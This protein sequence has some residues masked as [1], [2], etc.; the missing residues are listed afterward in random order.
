MA[1]LPRIVR[2]G[3][4]HHVLQRGHNRQPL[5]VD[6]E[7][8]RQWCAFLSDAALRH[9]VALHAWALL[10][11]QFQ[12]VATPA[13]DEALGLMMQ[14]LGRRYAGGF[15]RRHGRSGSLWEGRY[16]ACV[17]EPRQP[18]LDSLLF[19]D[20]LPAR[21]GGIGEAVAWPW[22][23]LRHHLGLQRDPMVTEAPLWWSLG[24]T[25]FEREAR[26][27]QLNEAGLDAAA[28]ASI[29][30]ALRRGWPIGSPAFLDSLQA[31]GG[32]RLAPRPRGRPPKSSAQMPQS[33][34]ERA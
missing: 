17:L 2:A 34:P 5:V 31:P 16:R 12:L 10:D 22:S 11:D 3:Q 27:R 18:L 7:D 8:R 14:S 29:S 13:S 15:N 23:S 26:Y 19:V 4:P 28:L 33:P 6:D 1:R 30:A 20:G 21:E 32:P 9:R 24:N 25:P